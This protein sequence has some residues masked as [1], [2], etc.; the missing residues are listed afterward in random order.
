MCKPGQTDPLPEMGRSY[1][2]VERL[3]SALEDMGIIVSDKTGEVYDSGM[4]VR[5][6]A[7][8]P[9]A[10]IAHDVI[11]ETIAPAVY[12]GGQLIQQAQI[13][14]GTVAAKE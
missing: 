1:R 9:M 2:H 10:G 8:E 6:M 3:Q 12:R 11:K 13:V 4:S 7:S 5:I 14:V